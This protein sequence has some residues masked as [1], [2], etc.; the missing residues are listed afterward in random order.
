MRFTDRYIKSLKPK[1]S[2]YDVNS[3]DGFVIRVF[4]SG[5]KSWMYVYRMNGRLRRMTLGSY[6]A[7]KLKEATDAHAE[8]RALK[9]NDVD[10]GTL[11]QEQEREHR[12]AHTVADLA[13]EY[14]E[15]H[16]KLKKR[17]W[18]EDQRMLEKD[19]LPHWG[20]R[21]AREITP[22]DVHMLLDRIVDRGAPIVANRTFEVIRRMFNFAIERHILDTSPCLRVK[23]PAEEN[24]RD[25]VLSPSEIRTFWRRL[26]H[27]DMTPLVRLALK[28]QLVTAQR[29]GEVMK[30]EWA[31]F[32]LQAGWWTIPAERSKNRLAHRVPLSP[33][34]L[35]LLRHIERRSIDTPWLFPN[36]SRKAPMTGSAPT[37]ALARNVDNSVTAVYDRHSYDQEKRAA[38]QGWADQLAQL[39]HFPSAAT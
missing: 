38:L 12:E 27:T 15:R 20:R 4:P 11:K 14:I 18:K 19:V 34:A 8:A 7:M 35:A 32:D 21:K 1:Q 24:Q 25:R 39:I 3:G 5:A 36:P 26:Y 10:P 23:A 2:R 28:L 37:R 29:R 9:N 6:P 13:R 31:D 17:S 33:L 16:A 22:H 30:A